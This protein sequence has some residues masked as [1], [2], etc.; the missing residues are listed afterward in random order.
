MDDLDLIILS[1]F[2]MDDLY[3]HEELRNSIISLLKPT[4]DKLRK[5]R[6]LLDSA[7]LPK[8]VHHHIEIRIE[9]I[10]DTMPHL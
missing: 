2:D 7:D 6:D 10:A 8:S 5:T 3:H 4:S 9:M 1:A